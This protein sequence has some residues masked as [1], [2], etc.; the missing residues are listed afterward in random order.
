MGPSFLGEYECSFPRIQIA[1]DVQRAVPKAGDHALACTELGQHGLS[2]PNHFDVIS[3][4]GIT[5]GGNNHCLDWIV[6]DRGDCG[7]GSGPIYA[8]GASWAWIFSA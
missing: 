2:E 8:V 6:Q 7:N 3:E 1:T 4:I 5:D